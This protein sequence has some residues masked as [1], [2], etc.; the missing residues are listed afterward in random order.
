MKKVLSVLLAA[1]MIASIC[2]VFAFGASG[3][4][5]ATSV[6]GKPGGTVNV[7]VSLNSNPGVISLL[8]NITYDPSLTLTK[9]TN[10]TVFSESDMGAGGDLSANPYKVSWGS[11]T[12][13]SNNTKTGTVVTLTFSIAANATSGQKKVTITADPD[14]TFNTNYTPVSFTSATGTI[15]VN[16]PVVP[17]ITATPSTVNIKIG[18]TATVT[19]TT[20]PAGQTVAVNII[21]L[22]HTS[23]SQSNGKLTFT[24]RSV[25]TDKLNLTMTYGGQTYSAPVTVNVTDIPVQKTLSS[26]AV[27]TKPAKT[28]YTVGET[29][30]TAGMVVR[31]TYSDGSTANV[32]GYTCSPT[33][34]GTAGTQTITVSY[35]EGGVTRTATFTVNVVDNPNPSVKC[36]LTLQ[37][38]S[39]VIA[40]KDTQRVTCSYAL[41]GDTSSVRSI[42][43]R[44]KNHIGGL[45]DCK[46]EE[47]DGNSIPLKIDANK[48]GSGTVDI[49]ILNTDTEE[50]LAE[51]TLD[52]TVRRRTVGEFLLD[53]FI[54][55]ILPFYALFSLFQ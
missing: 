24:G 14:S 7:T 13:T 12:S 54:Y 29:L 35:T 53:M 50:V 28:N 19:Y 40:K 4:L 10:G 42:T 55:L 21:S 49:S 47:W 45:I 30:N 52:V 11:Y 37:P 3:S 1:W 17:S 38:S 51:E 20:V 16:Q 25:G 44:Y 18:E 46:F 41:S 5:S 6:S 26:I 31:A 27:T 43:I 9:I 39:I 8:L 15:T 23:Y 32:T 22:S 33:T 48:I 36:T 34:L 2:C